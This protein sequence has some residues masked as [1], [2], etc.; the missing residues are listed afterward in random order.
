MRSEAPAQAQAD[1]VFLRFLLPSKSLSQVADS[2]LAGAPI[3]SLRLGATTGSSV[4]WL[5]FTQAGAAPSKR[6]SGTASGWPNTDEQ[7]SI[8]AHSWQSSAGRTHQENSAQ[9][10]P[11]EV[12]VRHISRTQVNCQPQ[13]SCGAP[14]QPS[15]QHW[16]SPR[17]ARL[18]CPAMRTCNDARRRLRLLASS[19]SPWLALAAP[20]SGRSPNFH[21]KDLEPARFQLAPRVCPVFF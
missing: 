4:L 12:R 10:L 8:I 6:R 18:F 7:E 13:G 5:L 17:R 11:L 2:P 20:K 19:P 3:G 14:L 1:C 15:L 16:S 21:V 9:G